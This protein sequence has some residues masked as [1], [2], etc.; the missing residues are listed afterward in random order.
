MDDE[1]SEARTVASFVRR[2]MALDAAVH[3]VFGEP[4]DVAGN[5]LD[6]QGRSVDPRGRP[7]D[8]R[9]Y[10]TDRNGRVVADEQ[11]DHGYTERVAERLADAYARDFVVQSTHLAAWAAWQALR[12]RHRSLDTWRLVRLHPADRKVDRA[13]LERLIAEAPLQGHA[14]SAPADAGRVLDEALERFSHYHRKR[15]LAMEV[16][17]VVVEPELALYYANRLS[18]FPGMAC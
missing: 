12:R 10:V 5:P 2:L 1:F 4:M 13:V 9:G 17:S 14:R 18:G 7:V 11:R 8:R 15:A 3:V 16:G 6:E